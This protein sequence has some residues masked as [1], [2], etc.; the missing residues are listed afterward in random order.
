MDITFRSSSAKTAPLEAFSRESL[1]TLAWLRASSSQLVTLD[2]WCSGGTSC[3]RREL[4][5]SRSPASGALLAARRA[6]AACSSRSPR[7]AMCSERP[8]P[9]G[10]SDVIRGGLYLTSDVI[11]RASLLTRGAIRLRGVP[12]RNVTSAAITSAS[13]L[14]RGFR[15]RR[16]FNFGC[17]PLALAACSL[18]QGD[19]HALAAGAERRRRRHGSGS[20]LHLCAVDASCAAAQLCSFAAAIRKR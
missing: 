19:G 11:C 2:R 9:R 16:S 4:G 7:E 17:N 18:G 8:L 6:A 1:V 3:T 15:G 20:R 13:R 14:R 10:T 5:R 12:G